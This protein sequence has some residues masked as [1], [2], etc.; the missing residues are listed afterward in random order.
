LASGGYVGKLSALRGAGAALPSRFLLTP[1]LLELAGFGGNSGQPGAARAIRRPRRDGRHR[2]IRQRQQWL[3][4]VDPPTRKVMPCLV[5]IRFQRHATLDQALAR[6]VVFRTGNADRIAWLRVGIEWDEI[7]VGDGTQRDIARADTQILLRV[8]RYIERGGEERGGIE[9]R[10]RSRHPRTGGI[11]GTKERQHT[12]RRVRL[13][14][15][16]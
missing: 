7:E 1:R 8:T 2:Q 12:Q 14:Q 9:N 10:A 15:F 6:G 11:G 3:I 16:A 13:L 4:I 5:A